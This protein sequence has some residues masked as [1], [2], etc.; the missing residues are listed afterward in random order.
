MQSKRFF[1]FENC[2]QFIVLLLQIDSRSREHHNLKFLVELM[3]QVFIDHSENVVENFHEGL[4]NVLEKFVKNL[5][6]LEFQNST[7]RGTKMMRKLSTQT[8]FQ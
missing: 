8:I 6:K 4:R 5:V 1:G 7:E 2:L 3:V